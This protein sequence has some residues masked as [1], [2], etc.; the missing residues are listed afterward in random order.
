MAKTSA[1]ITSTDPTTGK[2]LQKTL[3]DINPDASNAQIATFGGM[4]NAITG[5]GYVNTF[6]VDKVN[7]DLESG[8]G[9]TRPTPTLTLSESTTTLAD[10]KS[11]V[12]SGVYAKII[13][14]TYSGDAP[15]IATSFNPSVYFGAVVAPD[16]SQSDNTHNFI[17]FGSSN[18]SATVTTGFT[19]TIT[20]PETDNYKAAS[21]TFTVTA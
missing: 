3:T 5:N 7:C 15:V 9:D 4:L 14:L 17:M 10:L 16:T 8:G 18:L 6:R 12:T 1:I 2:T 20:A 11:A 19:I 21:A 13:S